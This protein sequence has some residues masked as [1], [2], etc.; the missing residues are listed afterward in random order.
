MANSTLQVTYRTKKTGTGTQDLTKEMKQ[1]GLTITDLKSGIDLAIGSFKTI[2]AAVQAMIGPTI[3]AA[4]EV[5]NLQRIIGGTAEESSKLIQAAD[6]M[7]ISAG[8]LQSAMEA[9]IKRGVEPTIEGIGALA[10]EYNAIESPIARTKFLM[11]KFGKSGADLGQLMEQGAEGIKALGDEA[12]NTGLVLSQDAVDAAR[13]FELSVDALGDASAGYFSLLAQQGIPVL[14]DLNNLLAEG[15]T[16][17]NQLEV[18]RRAGILTDREAASV[19]EA[20]K[21]G[22]FDVGG[23][24][25]YVQE[26][27]DKVAAAT[28]A[29]A[30]RYQGLADAADAANEAMAADAAA[31]RYQGLA[32][33]LG[34]VGVAQFDLTNKLDDSKR[35]AT[36]L[37]AALSGTMTDAAED[38]Q[39]VISETAPEI[40]RLTAQLA[41]YQAAQGQTFT[42]TTAASASVEEYELAQI[43]AATAAQKLAEFNGDSREEYLE[44]KIAADEAAGKVGTLG[45]QMGISQSFTADYTRQIMETAGSLDVLNNRQATA[46]EQLRKTTAEFIYQQIAANLD[47]AA[48]L[49]VGRTLGLVDEASYNTARAVLDLADKYDI[50][51]KAGIQAEEA[52]GGFAAGLAVIYDQAVIAAG[53][54]STLTPA[55]AGTGTAAETAAGKIDDY[56]ESLDG[57][58]GKV[59]TATIIT[60]LVT[61]G[62]LPAIGDDAGAGKAQSN[63]ASGAQDF[64]VPPGYPNDSYRV[65]LTSGE[66]VNV[67]PAGQVGRENSGGGGS[68]FNVTINAPGATANQLYDMLN[69]QDIRRRTGARS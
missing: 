29:A 64:I 10:D 33:A 31:G 43:K 57:L 41:R 18:A 48:A 1:A 38:Y 46:E 25:E 11:D 42:V 40:E 56:G 69:A 23:A 63:F 54:Q 13:E 51:G 16:L 8:T 34:V 45:E 49:E 50:N 20:V 66:V 2:V 47:A 53:G 59:V 67:T 32:D 36:L 65:G 21:W 17:T 15:I 22:Y 6:D 35:A 14:T 58:D 30:D 37:S 26:K 12:M 39:A 27:T 3:E 62:A 44:L 24:A 61:E 19:S 60:K 52:T 68:T 55:I 5:R 4:A 28:A 9:A 7:G